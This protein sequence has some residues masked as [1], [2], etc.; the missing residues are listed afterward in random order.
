VVACKFSSVAAERGKRGSRSSKGGMARITL[1]PSSSDAGMVPGRGLS[2]MA[3]P[4]S[5]K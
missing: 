5:S 1:M 4:W 3:L 2:R